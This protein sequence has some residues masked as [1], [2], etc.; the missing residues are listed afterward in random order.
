MPQLDVPDVEALNL[1][2]ACR[3]RWERS[4]GFSGERRIGIPDDRLQREA[5]RLGY[6]LEEYVHER[7]LLVEDLLVS[8]D[9][10][11]MNAAAEDD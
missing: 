11:R 2:I 9:V 8:C 4:A 6:V 3:N 10:E 1:V 7:V 5:E